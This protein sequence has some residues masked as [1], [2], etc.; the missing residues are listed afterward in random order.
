MTRGK[1][2]LKKLLNREREYNS[3]YKEEE[4]VIVNNEN[5]DHPNSVSEIREIDIDEI[6][7]EILKYGREYLID[8]FW[9]LIEEIWRQEGMPRE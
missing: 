3:Q 4:E 9:N 7:S 5:D 8:K 1:Q 6:I 2:Y